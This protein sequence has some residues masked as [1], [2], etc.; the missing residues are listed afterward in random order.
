[1]ER[2]IK[3]HR[4]CVSLDTF[5]KNNIHNLKKK[6]LIKDSGTAWRYCADLTTVLEPEFESQSWWAP[7][8]SLR[9]SH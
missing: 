3:A 5:G 8:D 7:V 4:G 6:S 2:S 1:M 9:S